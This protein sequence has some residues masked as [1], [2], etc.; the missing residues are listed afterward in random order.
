MRVKTFYSHNMKY[1]GEEKQFKFSDHHS[2]IADLMNVYT[3]GKQKTLPV[4]KHGAVDL[5]T[6]L[7]LVE[8]WNSDNQ[9]KYGMSY[10]YVYFVKPNEMYM[11]TELNEPIKPTKLTLTK[12]QLMDV[13]HQIEMKKIIQAIKL[14]RV[15]TGASLYDAKKYVDDLASQMNDE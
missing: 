9:M 10:N 4:D 11:H 5:E 8:W 14:V 13:K 6:A 15:F 12:E 1:E 7:Q 2:L 3:D